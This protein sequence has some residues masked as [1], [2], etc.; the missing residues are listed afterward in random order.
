MYWAPLNSCPDSEDVMMC[1]FLFC[2]VL[3]YHGIVLPLSINK[4][5]DLFSTA[6]GFIRTA[7]GV[8]F[9]IRSSTNTSQLSI[10]N[11]LIFITEFFAFK[12][13]L[14]DFSD[15]ISITSLSTQSS[16]TGVWGHTVPFHGTP[17]MVNGW[18]LGKPDIS[19]VS[20]QLTIVKCFGNDITI[21]Q[22]TTC[23][24]DKIGTCA[25]KKS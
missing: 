13:I 11:N 24:V 12:V 2:H 5:P 17:W 19:S 21:T 22:F 6:H 1:F 4:Q 15:T 10:G 3:L 23:S 18:W 14:K 16:T 9:R 8:S 7:S 25:T 20:S